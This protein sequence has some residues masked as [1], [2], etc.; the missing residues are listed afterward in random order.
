MGKSIADFRNPLST[1]SRKNILLN[2]SGKSLLKIRASH[3]R[4]GRIMIVTNVAVGCC[5]RGSCDGRA[6][7]KRTAKSCGPGAPTLALSFVEMIREATVA[8]KPGHRGE[9]EVSRKTI[10]RGKPE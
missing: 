2:P 8:K 6:R 1:P 9:R 3:P 5:G 7:L 10:A 4:E